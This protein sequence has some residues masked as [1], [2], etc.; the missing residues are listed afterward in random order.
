MIAETKIPAGGADVGVALTRDAAETARVVAVAVCVKVGSGV[1]VTDVV[2][3][4]VAGAVSDCLIVGEARI[5]VDDG[6]ASPVNGVNG[7]HALNASA[8]NITPAA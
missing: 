6:N 2:G 5:R 3:I 7:L 1:S 4:T 8:A